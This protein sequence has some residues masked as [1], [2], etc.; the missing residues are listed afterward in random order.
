MPVDVKC[1][2]I[3]NGKDSAPLVDAVL[4]VSDD[5]KRRVLAVVNKSP[6]SIVAF[7]VS[8]LTSAAA[9][10]ATVLDGDSPDAFNDIGAENRVVPRKTELKVSGGKVSLAPHSLSVIELK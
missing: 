9:L 3:S 4:T 7:D 2:K 5:G 10:N 1:G 6:D 8:S